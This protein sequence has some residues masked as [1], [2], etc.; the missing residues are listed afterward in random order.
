MGSLRSMRAEAKEK[1]LS[2][3][4]PV[5]LQS[6]EVLRV[7]LTEDGRLKLEVLQAEEHPKH[8]KKGKKRASGKPDQADDIR[9][10]FSDESGANPRLMLTLD[11]LKGLH[12]DRV[13]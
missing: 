8:W 1:E 10:I 6:G 7:T 2:K 12:I 9:I 5:F 11:N 3:H 4:G 13:R